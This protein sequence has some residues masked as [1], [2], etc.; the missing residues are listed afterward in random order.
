MVKTQADQKLPYEIDSKK[1]WSL[2]AITISMDSRL[3]PCK[4]ASICLFEIFPM[5]QVFSQII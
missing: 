4:Q 3:P 5:A 1:T 2:Q